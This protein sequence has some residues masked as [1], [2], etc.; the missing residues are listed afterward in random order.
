[1]L[2]D[3]P[4]AIILWRPAP[5]AADDLHHIAMGSLAAAEFIGCRPGEVY[6]AIAFGSEVGGFFCDI[7]DPRQVEGVKCQPIT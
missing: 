7:A 4:V 1:M 3:K 2:R 6:R 5:D